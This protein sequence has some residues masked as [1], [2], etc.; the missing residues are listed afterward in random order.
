MLSPLHPLFTYI[1][2]YTINNNNIINNLYHSILTSSS[3]LARLVEILQ[4]QC[5]DTTPQFKNPA[6]FPTYFLDQI[7][8]FI[9]T[10]LNGPFLA[11]SPVHEIPPLPHYL[12]L[13]SGQRAF[14]FSM[15]PRHMIVELIN[16]FF[17]ISRTLTNLCWSS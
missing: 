14:I 16:T 11:H 3:S 5:D 17:V 2:I 1:C 4:S 8:A 15:G 9:Q 10:D 12:I 7:Q 13:Y 6:L